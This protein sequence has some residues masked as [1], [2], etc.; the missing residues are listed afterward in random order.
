MT[1]QKGKAKAR[2]RKQAQSSRKRSHESYI[3]QQLAKIAQG[4]YVK[5][6]PSVINGEAVLDGAFTLIAREA[7]NKLGVLWEP[8]IAEQEYNSGQSTQVPANSRVKLKSRFNRK[9]IWNNMELLYE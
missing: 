7:L 4:I 2:A 1:K 6:R 5:M 9:I 8:E 3:N